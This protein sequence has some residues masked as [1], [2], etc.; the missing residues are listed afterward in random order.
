MKLENFTLKA[1]LF[2]SVYFLGMQA[3]GQTDVL[4]Q[5]NDQK[6]TGWNNSETILNPTSVTPTT[7]GLLNK[8]NVDDQI[9]AQPLIV[10]GVTIGGVAKNLLIVATVNNTVYAFD[11]DNT[12]LNPYW[13]RNFTPPGEVPPNSN[14]IHPDLCSGYTDFSGRLSGQNGSF[15]IVGTPVVD[16]STNTLYFFSRYRD[17][18]VDNSNQATTSYPASGF[19]DQMSALDLSTGLGKFNSGFTITSTNLTIPGTGA[20]SSGGLIPFN[21]RRQNQRGGLLLLNGIVY[22]SFAGHCDMDNYHGWVLGFDATDVTNIKIKYVTT[23][24]DGRGGIWMS[25]AGIATDGTNLFF[26]TGN[27]DDA[28]AA[29]SAGN[30]GTGVVKAT[31]NLI[32]G[33]LDNVSW[34]HRTTYSQDDSLDLD[35]GTG[36]VLIPNTNLMVSAHKSGNMYL[37]KQNG[38]TGTYDENSPN[39]LDTRDMGGSQAM[40][41]SS[42]AYFGGSST[43]Y[44]Y[45]FSEYSPLTAF[46]VNAA[47]LGTASTS[48]IPTNVGE[49]G[50]YLSVSSNGSDPS[51]AIIWVTHATGNNNANLGTVPGTMHAVNATNL[52]QELW[53]SDANPLDQLGFFAKMSPATVANGKVYVPTFSNTLN[54]YG[55]LSGNSRCVNNAALTGTAS[56]NAPPSP[57][58]TPDQAIDGN[59]TPPGNNVTTHW[60]GSGTASVANPIWLQVDLGSRYDV[61]RVELLWNSLSGGLYDYAVNFTVDISDDG[62][63]WT[64]INTVTGNSFATV[65]LLNVYNEN[66]TGRYLRVNITQ[67]GNNGTAIQEFRIFG[68]I[69]NSC[70]SP[71]V[72]N[73]TATN[74]TQNSATLNWNRVAG[75]NNYIVQYKPST[76]SSYITRHVADA[77]TSST[78]SLSIGA[79]TCGFSYGFQIQADCGSGS[80]SNQAV[81]SPF[82]MQSCSSPCSNLTRFSHGDMGDITLAGMTCYSGSTWTIQ[83]EGAGIGGTSD[84]FQINYT[85]LAV[86]EEYIMRIASQDNVNGQ[87]QAVIMMRED[88]TDIGRYIAVGKTGNGNLLLIYRNA[89]GGTSVTSS[90]V[91]TGGANYFRIVKAGTTYSAYYGN[92]VTGGP[93]IPM[94]PTQDLGFGTNPVF[95]AMGVSSKQSGTMSTATFDNLTENSAVLPIQLID[96]TAT[97]VQND[98]VALNWHTA[99]EENNDHF[100]IERSVDGSAYQKIMTIKA[101]GTSSTVQSYAAKDMNPVNGINFYRLKQVDID[102]RYSFSAI[103]KVKFGKDV[104]PIIYPNPTTGLFTAVTGSEEIMEIAIYTLQG[105]AVQFVMGNNLQEDMRVNVSSLSTGIYV[106]K[107]KTQSKTYQLKL[108]KQ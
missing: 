51:S 40:S 104:A 18:N 24:N 36:V 25:G 106:L 107:I 89:V 22:V 81:A 5:H 37:F 43:H 12:T 13:T 68:T 78:L 21:T 95:I 82:Y 73:M 55:L 30:V 53:N 50:G 41:H 15:G 91:N 45:T 20:G 94:G 75:I 31:P 69:A 76:I 49:S 48:T 38:A 27:S 19:F 100:E 28:S 2:L 92:L 44:V 108:L 99:S 39:V 72:G 90:A 103:Q 23:P 97:N 11:A 87:N 67:G 102:N 58:S 105:R 57:P 34:L 64:S 1:I 85:G 4:T 7:F 63:N 9:Y 62:T 96:F 98:Y 74:V 93:W 35:F 101:V 65:P 3:Q 29:T 42:I 47:S 60:Y 16:K 59:P 10:T 71:V 80:L 52:Q 86:D 70:P 54:V 84:Q 32:T 88:L 77:T 79:L 46:P 66:T 26:G 61:C 83:G 8:I 14:D 56:S 33:S 6:R 17:P